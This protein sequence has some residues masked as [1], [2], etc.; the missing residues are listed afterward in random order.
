MFFCHHGA[1]YFLI[2]VLLVFRLSNLRV[3][4]SFSVFQCGFEVLYM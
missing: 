3:W 1:F 2:V 4:I